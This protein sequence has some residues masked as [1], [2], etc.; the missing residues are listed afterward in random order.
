MKTKIPLVILVVLLSGC[1]T[2]PATKDAEQ[3][4]KERSNL[5]SAMKTTS[6]INLNQ[7]FSKTAESSNS[8]P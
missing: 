7:A 5:P 3:T 2:N 4:P 6:D 1:A 8:R